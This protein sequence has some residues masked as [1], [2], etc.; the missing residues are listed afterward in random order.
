MALGLGEAALRPCRR[1][2]SCRV[3]VVKAQVEVTIK[4]PQD[5]SLRVDIQTNF[6]T[7]ITTPLLE[8]PKI[9]SW[10]PWRALY[11]YIVASWFT[12]ATSM[13]C[14]EIDVAFV[15]KTCFKLNTILQPPLGSLSVNRQK[16]LIPLKYLFQVPRPRKHASLSCRWR[17][18]EFALLRLHTPIHTTTPSWT[19]WT[20]TAS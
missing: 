6:C 15:A 11:P 10:S 5:L 20:W 2:Q 12:I 9:A 4:I 3:W 8:A 17:R 13:L 1:R 14:W 16:H 18:R 19:K 7:A